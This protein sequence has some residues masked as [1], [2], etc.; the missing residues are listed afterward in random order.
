MDINLQTIYKNIA[1]K[2]SI[3]GGGSPHTIQGGTE[4]DDLSKILELFLEGIRKELK[5]T[6]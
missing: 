3:K 4:A 1:S 5:V 6:K 2:F